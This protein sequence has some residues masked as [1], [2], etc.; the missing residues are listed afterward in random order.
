MATTS[1]KSTGG[2]SPYY[3]IWCK[4]DKNGEIS[5]NILGNVIKCHYNEILFP[6]ELI[7]ELVYYE[8]SDKAI[9]ILTKYL[10]QHP[11]KWSKTIEID[12]ITG[13]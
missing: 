12:R 11:S 9:S 2:T 7:K 1:I 5:I 6:K 10:L 13:N 4:S 3:L 8:W